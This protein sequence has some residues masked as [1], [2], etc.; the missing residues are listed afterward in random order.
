[1][2]AR[3]KIGK[4][5]GDMIK[6]M[7]GISGFYDLACKDSTA[8]YCDSYHNTLMELNIERQ[9]ASLKR[10]LPLPNERYA[11]N[12]V[13]GGIVYAKNKLFIAPRDGTS[14][15]VY[16]VG[17]GKLQEI[18]LKLDE[19]K[20]DEYGNFFGEIFSYGDYVFFSPGRYRAFLKINIHTLEIEEIAGWYQEIA[21]Y[22][23]EPRRVIFSGSVVVGHKAYFS[24]WQGNYVFELDLLSNRTQWH[25][26]G[27]IDEPLADICCDGR[28]FWLALR[29]KPCI[30]RW[31]LKTGECKN[32]QNVPDGAEFDLGYKYLF[33]WKESLYAIPL[34]GNMLV[35]FDKKSGEARNMY[36]LRREPLKD[37]ALGH[38]VKNNCLCVKQLDEGKALI[39][40][41]PDANVIILDLQTENST[42][43][44]L[45]I[46]SEMDLQK[47]VHNES[48]LLCMGNKDKM[49]CENGIFG[50][51]DYLTLLCEDVVKLEM[52]D[53]ELLDFG[54]KI[55]ASI[56]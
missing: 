47:I 37:V 8:W 41:V 25:K 21:P 46:S 10:F 11:A 13:Y 1:M 32:Y 51:E 44:P 27:E 5:E 49:W 16:D 38:W 30:W 43:F 23:N 20:K 18:P 39:Y 28:Y 33:S 31:E 7:S 53:N 26:V 40:S 22:I 50:L 12:N 45:R 48:A 34:Y 42:T 17:S 14:I 3:R 55:Y 9:K 54:G 6:E 29:E 36:D 24:F 15:C 2:K 35:K 4:G 19:W 56:V 52:R